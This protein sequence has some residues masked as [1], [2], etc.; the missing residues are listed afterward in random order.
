MSVCVVVTRGGAGDLWWHGS[1]QLADDHP[2]TQLGDALLRSPDDVIRTYSRQEMAAMAER[3]GSPQL[4]RSLLAWQHGA[5]RSDMEQYAEQLWGLI[6]KSGQ[7]APTDDSEIVR[8]IRAD[9]RAV[10]AAGGGAYRP[11]PEERGSSPRSTREP[12]M[13]D[14]E[15]T[16]KNAVPREKKYSDDSVVRFGKDKD[17]NVYSAENNP[18]KV[19]SKAHDS[20]VNY[21]DGETVKDLLARGGT[22]RG[23]VNYDV[24]KGFIVLE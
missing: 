11:H 16:K 13:S 21:K 19:G 15:T 12:R 7:K 4:Q 3:L 17:G 22:T 20:F 14:T 24:D 18:K 23:D 1:T 9:R 5:A 2:I 10:R 8:V 6:R